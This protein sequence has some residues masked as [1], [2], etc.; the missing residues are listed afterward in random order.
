MGELTMD[1]DLIVLSVL[2]VGGWGLLYALAQWTVTQRDGP[3]LKDDTL[4][5]TRKYATWW[6]LPEHRPW[7][8]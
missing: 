4:L 1:T 7:W 5:T 8:K 2:L 6:N 3:P